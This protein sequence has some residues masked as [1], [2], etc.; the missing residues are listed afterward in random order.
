MVCLVASMALRVPQPAALVPGMPG[1][2]PPNVTLLSCTQRQWIVKAKSVGGP[3]L[4]YWLIGPQT[5][6]S[7]ISR[8]NF[9]ANT[10]AHTPMAPPTVH[11][12]E[13]TDVSHLVW[14]ALHILPHCGQSQ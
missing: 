7:Y 10:L 8:G 11:P 1:H 3:R 6:N 2:K 5:G 13:G 14:Q 9:E 4:P 12:G